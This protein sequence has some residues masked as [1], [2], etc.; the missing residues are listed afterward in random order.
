MNYIEK[1]DAYNERRYGRPWMA[2]VTTTLTKDFQFIDWEGLNGCAGE[3]C[4]DAEPGTL[5]AYGQKDIR[6]G[7]GGVDG[8][9]LTMPDGS[10]PTCTSMAAELRRMK[11][12]ARWRHLAQYF[13][14]RAITPPSEEWRRMEWETTCNASAERYSKMLGVTNPIIAK[15]ADALGLTNQPAEPVTAPPVLDIDMSAFGF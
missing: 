8:Y 11:P 4:F 9:Q 5:I 15:V 3:F 13:L 1:S 10:L 14:D 6:K 7:R 12:E 2:F